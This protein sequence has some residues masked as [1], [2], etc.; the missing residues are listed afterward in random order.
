MHRYSLR[1]GSSA[2]C[3]AAAKALNAA[4]APATGAPAVSCVAP[5]APP[6][7]NTGGAGGH[8][9]VA[10]A[11]A[12]ASAASGGGW[13]GVLHDAVNKRWFCSGNGGV[14]ASTGA[15]VCRDRTLGLGPS[16]SEFTDAG[17]CGGKGRVDATGQCTCDS[18]VSARP[19]R[20]SPEPHTCTRAPDRFFFIWR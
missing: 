3:E 17:T 10:T 6:F 13:C 14:D 9:L 16:C 19:V 20:C 1:A 11:A 18:P 12:A 4:L 15:C 7:N 8:Y 5:G 2:N